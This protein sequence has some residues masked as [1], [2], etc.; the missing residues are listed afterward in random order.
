MAEEW[1]LTANAVLQNAAPDGMV[2][3]GQGIGPA[4]TRPIREALEK[5]CIS[6]RFNVLSDD[7]CSDSISTMI[8]RNLGL[9]HGK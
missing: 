8:V 9:R 5:S 1:G 7:E 4:R 2:S 3:G 6:Q